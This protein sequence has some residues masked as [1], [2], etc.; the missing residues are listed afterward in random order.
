MS[1]GSKMALSG[2]YT[3]C[4]ITI[5][6]LIVEFLDFCDGF[7]NQL[8][9]DWRLKSHACIWSFN[10]AVVGLMHVSAVRLRC[11]QFCPCS[12]TFQWFD[13]V[14][15]QLCCNSNDLAH[16]LLPYC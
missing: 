11:R 10:T 6:W 2:Y 1:D 12:L 16:H 8:Y 4:Y 7:A 3:V 13:G 14:K 15:R 9:Y 5:G